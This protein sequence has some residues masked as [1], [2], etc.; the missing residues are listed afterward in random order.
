MSNKE[1]FGSLP[2]IALQ[3]GDT[4]QVV[5]ELQGFLRKY[6]YLKEKDSNFAAA[7]DSTLPDAAIGIFDDATEEAL[8]NYQKFHGLPV[9]GEL[10][11]A[12][13]TEMRKPRCGIPDRPSII[14]AITHK[15]EQQDLFLVGNDGRVYTS[16]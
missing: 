2:A 16:W 8:R 1:L 4:G 10:D 6:G 11:R 9:T 13:V 12:T 5:T 3:T 15:L 14:G 7:R